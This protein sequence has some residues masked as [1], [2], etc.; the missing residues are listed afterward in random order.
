MNLIDYRENKYSQNGEDGIIMEIFRRLGITRGWFVEFGAWDGKHFSNCYNLVKHHDWSGIFI[1]GD[2][3][4]Y[5]DLLKTQAAFPEKLQAICTMVGFEDED[6]LDRVLARTSTPN[7]FD[8]LSI[9]IDSYDWQV[10]QA[11]EKYRPSVVII[12]SNCAI[13]PEIYSIHNPPASQGAS[14]KALV[15]LGKQKG[16]T[17]VCHT[18]NCFFVLNKLVPALG[19]DSA[20][21]ADPEKLFNHA[22]RRK[23]LLVNFV[24]KV[25]PEKLLLKIFYLLDRRRQPAKS[26]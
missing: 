25:V 24:R 22:K 23:E 6:K 19:L 7:S 10:W 16:Y 11:L 1:E 26:A 8:L 13:S 18:G 21:L 20:L 3:Q 15:D 5:Q 14:F 17:L 9:D 4:K 12:E 2:P